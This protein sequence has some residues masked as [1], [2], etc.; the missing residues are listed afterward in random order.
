MWTRATTIAGEQSHTCRAAIILDLSSAHSVASMYAWRW[1]DD[2]AMVDTGHHH[3]ILP[4][5]A[6]HMGR[7]QEEAA[8]DDRGIA[9]SQWSTMVQHAG[10]Q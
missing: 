3:R 9:K 6:C 7:A 5:R 2:V 1:Y 10:S 4:T 8:E